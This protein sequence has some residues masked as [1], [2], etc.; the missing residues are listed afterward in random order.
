MVSADAEV[1]SS[2]Q[3]M[4]AANAFGIQTVGDLQKIQTC[5][6]HLTAEACARGSICDSLRLF[7]RVLIREQ[8]P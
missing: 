2:I 7:S 8:G 6:A 3:Q 5:F 1:L 4:Q